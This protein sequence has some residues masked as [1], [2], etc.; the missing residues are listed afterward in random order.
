MIKPGAVFWVLRNI[1][2]RLPALVGMTVVHLGQTLFSVAFALGIQDVI[3]SAAAGDASAFNRACWSLASII[4]GVVVCLTA[5]RY[6]RERL[7]AELDRDWKRKLLHGL[8]RGEYEAVSAYHSG[9]L[10]HCMNDDVRA[11]D[12]GLVNMLPNAAAMVVRL[13]AVAAVLLALTPGFA[14][15]VMP[16]GAVMILATGFVRRRTKTLNKQISKANGT[17]S[18]FLQET[19]EN[20]LMV[21]ALDIAD[22]MEHRADGLLEKRFDLQ[23]KRR[24]IG[25][26]SHTAARVVLQ[27]IGFVTLVWCAAQLFYGRMTFGMLMTVT[28][29]VGQLQLPFVNLSSIIPQYLAMTASAERLMELEKICGTEETEPAD[30]SNL[31]RDMKCLRMENLCFSYDREIVLRDGTFCIPKNTFTVITGSSGAGK[32]TLLKLM[33]G[34]LRPETGCMFV[35]HA[36]GKTLLDRST[37][38]MFA[39][40]PQGNMLLSGTLRENLTVTRP[41]ATEEELRQAIYVSAMDEYVNQ[42][43]DGLDTVLGENGTGLSEGQAQRLAIGRAVLSQAPILL[44]D[45]STS[46]LDEETEYKVLQRICQLSN[47]TCIAVTH[48]QAARELADMELQISEMEIQIKN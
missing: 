47:R 15:A 43:P 31:Y 29:L 1:K 35:E 36:G 41:N 25:L 44:L 16:V 39:Y 4:L 12:D 37:R 9:A 20:L 14:L 45:E 40:V 22:E 8:L 42:L 24:R 21:Q 5:Y 19:L 3:D 28:Q 13:V 7:N 11:V 18:G 38:R 2:K 6:L 23:R 48:R 17:V 46:A 33:L 26:L 32:S 34:V 27:T 30:I 10:I